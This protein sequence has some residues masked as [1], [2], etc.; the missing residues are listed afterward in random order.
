MGNYYNSG[1]IINYDGE[2]VNNFVKPY[3]EIDFLTTHGEKFISDEPVISVMITFHNKERYA[4]RCLRSF[5]NQT[6]TVPYEVVAID[7]SSTD[8]TVEI[9]KQYPKVRYFKVDYK[10]AAKAR[11]FGLKQ[12]RGKYFCFFD[13]DDFCYA[14]YLETLYKGI[15]GYDVCATRY[16]YDL[17]TE[18]FIIPTCNF[19]EYDERVLSYCGMINTPIMVRAELGKKLKWSPD[20]FCYEDWNISLQLRK[21]KAKVNLI[22][23]EKWEYVYNVDSKWGSGEVREHRLEN[24]KKVLKLHN[25]K[26]KKAEV[27]FFTLIAQDRTLDAYFDCVHKL[28]MP[29]EKI[30]WIIYIDSNDL[31]LLDKVK[32]KA[33]EF[34]F[35]TTKI[36]FA[37]KKDK[38]ENKNFTERADQITGNLKRMVNECA[39]FN[40]YTPYFFMLE[41]DTLCPPDAFKKLW[42]LIKKDE[43]VVYASGVEISKCNDRHLGV[44]YLKE[45]DE[46][47]IN[48]RL[49]PKPKKRG[50]ESFDSGGWYCWIGKTDVI[51]THKFR[52][53]EDGRFLGPDTLMVFDLKKRGFKCLTDWSVS[54]KHYDYK[55]KKWLGVEDGKGYEIHYKKTVH[56]A[57]EPV[58]KKLQM[59]TDY[60]IIVSILKKERERRKKEKEKNRIDKNRKSK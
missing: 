26:P 29:K 52:I 53:I 4:E 40:N 33:K 46:G 42:K 58:I 1:D 59:K 16:K 25:L 47:N 11:N 45:D 44:G 13:G 30:H 32:A 3:D 15:Q 23:E 39:K 50:I 5:L 8:R 60:Q 21:M 7:D 2:I 57:Y 56:N 14:D 9:I 22:R 36:Y 27:T 20:L 18:Q 49:M 37:N 34:K 48:W 17:A 55:M 43:K 35:L 19:F 28:E 51:R 41:D 10:S 38:Y 6:I 31:E 54:C 12:M 24:Y